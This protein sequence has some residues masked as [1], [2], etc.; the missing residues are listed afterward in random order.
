MWLISASSE[1]ALDV[2]TEPA[3]SSSGTLW[4]KRAG[5]HPTVDRAAVLAGDL[6]DIA[7]AEYLIDSGDAYRQRA[8]CPLA[9]GRDR[10][11]RASF[12]N[13]KG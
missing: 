8:C 3:P 2:R 1:P 10:S 6:L 9:A 4:R 7:R 11:P 13:C 12:L 5:A